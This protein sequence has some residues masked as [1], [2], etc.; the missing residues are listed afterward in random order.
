MGQG[1]QGQPQ[2]GQAQ[3]TDPQ[4]SEAQQPGGQPGQ[5]TPGPGG[6]SGGRSGAARSPLTAE[7]LL[8]RWSEFVGPGGNPLT[9]DAYRDWMDRLGEVEGLVPE[10]PLREEATRIR[11]AAAEMRRDLQRHS[12]VPDPMDIDEMIVKPLDS[13]ARRVAAERARIEGRDPS[14]RLDR[15]PVPAEFADEVREYFQRLGAGRE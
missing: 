9:T 4:S 7:Q 10:G 14:I 1:G 15:D 2:P 3:T 5:A 12:K 6:S 11:Q 13:L 8:D